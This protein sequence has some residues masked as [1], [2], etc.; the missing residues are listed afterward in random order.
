MQAD[1]ARPRDRRIS[2]LNMGRLLAVLVIERPSAGRLVAR[3]VKETPV[4]MM[5]PG[6]Q[7][8]PGAQ[9]RPTA[10]TWRVDPAHSVA[11][12][13][14]RV[15][16]R[17]ARGRL[18]LAGRVVIAEPIGDSTAWLTAAPGHARTRLPALY[19]HLAGPR[20]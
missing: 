13:A 12:F 1:H 16:G 8:K 6:I 20:F 9:P 2:P 4:T 11:S 15:A 10:G 5:K 14:A 7:F 19:R 18:P 17:P 3:Y